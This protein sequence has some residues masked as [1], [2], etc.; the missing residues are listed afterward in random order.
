[1]TRPA[2]H[3]HGRSKGPVPGDPQ[4][5]GNLLCRRGNA[6]KRGLFPQSL[7]RRQTEQTNERVLVGYPNW[8]WTVVNSLRAEFQTADLPLWHTLTAQALKFFLSATTEGVPTWR[9][10]GGGGAPSTHVLVPFF[11]VGR[12]STFQ[13]EGEE[14]EL[15]R[16]AKQNPMASSGRRLSL[17]SCSRSPN[18]AL[19]TP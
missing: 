1:M 4:G 17:Q 9:R 19:Y 8:S 13:G 6:H 7:Y 3:S 10:I 18:A 15:G 16:R 14:K 2:S 12:P 11:L 5:A